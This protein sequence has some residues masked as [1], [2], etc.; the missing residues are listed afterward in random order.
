VFRRKYNVAVDRYTAKR[1]AS[2][3]VY[4]APVEGWPAFKADA[5]C[6]GNTYAET[7]KWC[8][9]GQLGWDRQANDLKRF[10][11]KCG[12]DVVV[13]VFVGCVV[14]GVP[15]LGVGVI[16]GAIDGG[17]TGLG[18]RVGHMLWDAIWGV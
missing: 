9:M 15:T 5:K 6:W 2:V 18:D 8:R 13:G 12:G 1:G 10:A 4:R 7:L 3:Y 17:L 16:P 14:G 11:V